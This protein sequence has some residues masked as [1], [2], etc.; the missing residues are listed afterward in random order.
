MEI[1]RFVGIECQLEQRRQ[2]MATLKETVRQMERETL[3]T[4]K[5]RACAVAKKKIA[6]NNGTAAKRRVA[7]FKRFFYVRIQLSI[8]RKNLNI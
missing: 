2:E 3:K 7:N 4:N 8:A 5:Y 1:E 6:H